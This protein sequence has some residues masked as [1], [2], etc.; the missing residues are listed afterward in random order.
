VADDDFAFEEAQPDEEPEFNKDRE[1]EEERPSYVITV[2]GKQKQG[3][4]MLDKIMDH[5]EDDQP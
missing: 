3:N 5:E 2:Y 4:D 1:G